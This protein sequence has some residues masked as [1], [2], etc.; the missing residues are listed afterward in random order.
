MVHCVATVT[1][2]LVKPTVLEISPMPSKWMKWLARPSFSGEVL[3]IQSY[4]G[5][6]LKNPV[7]SPTLMKSY[8]LKEFLWK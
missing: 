6:I 4:E 8:K 5:V 7:E 1:L 2:M 3:A